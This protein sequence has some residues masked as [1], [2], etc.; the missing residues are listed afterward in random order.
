LDSLS[1]VDSSSAEL[2]IYISNLEPNPLNSGTKE[3]DYACTFLKYNELSDK[4]QKK[5]DN[6]LKKLN[7]DIDYDKLLIA[8]VPFF[9]EDEYQK[10]KFV[11]E[12]IEKFLSFVSSDLISY[13]ERFLDI[14]ESKALNNASEKELKH[15][16][17]KDDILWDLI[18][19]KIGDKNSLNYSNYNNINEEDFYE[20]IEKYE[21]IINFKT[22]NFQ[23]YNKIVNL[24][25]K[26][27]MTN[28]QIRSDEFIDT[29]DNEIYSIVF[30]NTEKSS[31]EYI[32]RICS[33]IVAKKI[34]IKNRTIEDF[35]E[36]VN[37]YDN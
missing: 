12:Q 17:S 24:I 4:S 31:N 34:F 28:N 3:F 16:I 1:D 35:F 14:W 15:R 7:K 33:K 36:R 26:V 19:I 20:A 5:I 2:L 8:K 27:K 22:S 21:D 6:Q 37:N 29:Y 25:D 13:K 9:G 11:I 18:V 10:Q 32:E 23:V 30:N